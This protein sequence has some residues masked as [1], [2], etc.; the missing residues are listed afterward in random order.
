[1]AAGNR[2]RVWLGR[3]WPWVAGGAAFALA[4]LL[5]ALS[6]TGRPETPREML[7]DHQRSA[8]EKQ[9]AQMMA[10]LDGVRSAEILLREPADGSPA[11][12][13][14][15]LDMIPGEVLGPETASAVA[16]LV[17][18]AVPGLDPARIVVVDARDPARTHRLAPDAD[19]AHEGAA[20][21][22]LRAQV[23]RALAEKIRGLFAGM[24]IECVAVVSA[25]L[26]LDRIEERLVEIDPGG[27]G[28]FVVREERTLEPVAGIAFSSA[29]AAHPESGAVAGRSAALAGPVGTG[30]RGA[31]VETR[32]TEFEIGRLTREIV[33]SPGGLAKVNVSVV[34]FDR[35]RQA[36]DGSW[37]YDRSVGSEQNVEKY[38][39]LVA[40][41]VGTDLRSVEL[42]YMPS[43][44]KTPPEAAPARPGLEAAGW[45][46]VAILVVAGA[47]VAFAARRSIARRAEVAAE[48]DRAPPAPSLHPA[49]ELRREAAR[50]ASENTERAAAIVHRWIA[51]EGVS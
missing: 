18:S 24:Q 27:K 31:P 41:A 51:R 15:T 10:G 1:M 34:I 19:V 22:R 37:E 42:Q 11:G 16:G 47:A 25:E 40:N 35:V 6:L 46:A 30:V 48:V 13:S 33:R 20:V 2:A 45:L 36:A 39:Q 23:E 14:V 7:A 38:S 5:W 26:D 29:A 3:H 4:G 44:W 17:A 8:R 28:E 43:P 21:L 12:A 32:R 49:E 50:G 9:I